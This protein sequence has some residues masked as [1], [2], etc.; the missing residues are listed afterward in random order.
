M[1]LAHN[2]A[3]A[4][5][6]ARELML[7]FHLVDW[8]KNFVKS[9]VR[10]PYDRK[11]NYRH[12]IISQTYLQLKGDYKVLV[13]Y[14]KYFVLARQNRPHDFRASGSGIFSWPEVLPEGLL[15]YALKVFS[16]FNSPFISLDIAFDGLRFHTLEFQF[17]MF[18]TFTLFNAPI[19]F[20]KS[21]DSWLCRYEKSILE[22]EY[23]RSVSL[24][25]DAGSK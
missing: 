25:L 13:Y 14:D 23:A 18:G 20:E 17:V 11:S 1:K 22:E 21:G 5:R 2:K 4:I 7:S 3:E 9:Y 16:S 24:F 10:H 19:Y 8:A 12:G 6:H 15:D